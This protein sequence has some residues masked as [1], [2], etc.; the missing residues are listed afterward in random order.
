MDTERLTELVALS[1]RAKSL[2]QELNLDFIALMADMV[3][4]ESTHTLYMAL[5]PG[6]QVAPAGEQPQAPRCAA[7]P[8]P[9]A[10]ASNVTQLMWYRDRKRAG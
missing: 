3:V 4:V 7:A 9:A 6:E 2:A 10:Y 5:E 1:R 8:K